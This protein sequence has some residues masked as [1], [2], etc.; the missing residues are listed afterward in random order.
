MVY[1]TPPPQSPLSI[2]E[3]L[4]FVS[5]SSAWTVMYTGDWDADNRT[6]A[7]YAGQ[8]IFL[9]RS[10]S[11]LTPMLGHV[12]RDM[13]RKGEFNGIEVGFFHRLAAEISGGQ[14]PEPK[15]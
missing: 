14:G 3:H 7:R 11:R 1:S 12:A 6:G 15:P 5:G 13:M 10:D 8:L 2:E 9:M 4:D